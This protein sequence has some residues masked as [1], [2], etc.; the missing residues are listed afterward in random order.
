MYIVF[1]RIQDLADRDGISMKQLHENLGFE[2][3]SLYKLNSSAIPQS[4]KLLK[5]ADY[6]HVAVD[7]LVGRTD[8][9]SFEDITYKQSTLRIIEELEKMELSNLDEQTIVDHLKI[10]HQYILDK[11]SNKE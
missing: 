7:Y 8:N 6:F 2:K 10:F 1:Q 4:D 3:T 11:Q 5:I 9:P